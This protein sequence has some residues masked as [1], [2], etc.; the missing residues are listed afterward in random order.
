MVSLRRI[1]FTDLGTK[2]L[3]LILA[4]AVYIH[5]F[6]AQERE[7]AYRVPLEIAP[8]PAGLTI[9]SDPPSDVRVRVRASGK[10]LLKLK[11]RRFDAQI[12]VESPRPGVLQRPILGSDLR[13]PRG[14]KIAAIEVIEPR[15]LDLRIER[16]GTRRVPVAVRSGP[17]RAGDRALSTRPSVNPGS[18]DLIG[19]GT[20]IAAI[21]SVETEPVSFDVRRTTDREVALIAPPGSK[22]EPARVTV[23]I[24][25][26]ARDERRFPGVSIELNPPQKDR[27]L[28]MQ[29]TEAEVIVSGAASVV[30]GIGPS[31]VRVIGD[32]GRGT[33]GSQRIRLRAVIAG[34]PRAVPIE[35]R[36]LPDTAS[37]R[38]Q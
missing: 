16:L 24:E 22:V 9:A 25:T 17:A 29:P 35:I 13:I 26:E 11:T 12:A 15:T 4:L 18:V 37:V 5:V 33:A 8:L 19:P 7:M 27:L 32:I 31:A 2:I 38:L 34:L 30:D 20:R 10:D 36:P 23:H 14:I 6:S 28:W 1:L 3:S 21:D